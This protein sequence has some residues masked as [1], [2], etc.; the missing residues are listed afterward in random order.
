MTMKSKIIALFLFLF[1]IGI[2][3][4]TWAEREVVV[5]SA[6]DVRAE[7]TKSAPA[8]VPTKV[9]TAEERPVRVAPVKKPLVS[10]PV[11]TASAAAPAEKAI[12]TPASVVKKSET[13]TPAKSEDSKPVPP[14]SFFESLIQKWFQKK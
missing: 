13:Q 1:F 10:A 9:T 7:M 8:A 2:A 4:S 3:T 12:P 6:A 5:R 11:K 14:K